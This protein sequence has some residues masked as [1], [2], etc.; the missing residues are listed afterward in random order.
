[1]YNVASVAI[2]YSGEDLPEYPVSFFLT[3]MTVAC[4]IIFTKTKRLVSVLANYLKYLEDFFFSHIQRLT[5]FLL[6]R[7]SQDQT[8]QTSPHYW[9]TL[10]QCTT[11]SWFP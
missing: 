9:H 1:M 2:L 5:D 3:Q 6:I 8:Y 7:L 10:L 4:K 11:C